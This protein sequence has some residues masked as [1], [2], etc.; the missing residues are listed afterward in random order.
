MKLP[1]PSMG[2][3]TDLD[4]LLEKMPVLHDPLAFGI[5]AE[6]ISN[7]QD[8]FPPPPVPPL[9]WASANSTWTS[10]RGPRNGGETNTTNVWSGNFISESAVPLRE[11][12]RF[13][14][15]RI[16][17]PGAFNLAQASC[18]EE[19]LRDLRKSR[20]EEDPDIF[21]HQF[22]QCTLFSYG[23]KRP[24]VVLTY[25]PEMLFFYAEKV[26]SFIP[27]RATDDGQD[28][29][30]TFHSKDEFLIHIPL[31]GHSTASKDEESLDD[32]CDKSSLAALRW[33]YK[34]KASVNF[35]R[36]VGVALEL[37]E[38]LPANPHIV[39]LWLSE[40]IKTVI[41]PTGI[42]LTDVDD[43]SP[44]L[45]AA[46]K[47]L[48][49]G[50]L[51]LK[52]VSVT[53]R[54][55]GILT[56]DR[57]DSMQAYIEYLRGVYHESL[58]GMPEIPDAALF[59]PDQPLHTDLTEADYESFELDER[60]YADYEEAIRKYIVDRQGSSDV[61][62]VFV[63][64]VVGCGRGP[65]VTAAINATMSS[66]ARIRIYALEKNPLTAGIL[67]GKCDAEW[68]GCDVRVV[69]EDMRT[70]QPPEKID[71]LLSEMLGG[72]GDNE[73]SPE[74]LAG[75]ERFLSAKG[76]S[77]PETYT[78]YIY[79]ISSTKLY[80]LFPDGRLEFREHVY[81]FDVDCLKALDEP[82]PVF[83]FVHPS[84]GN[85]EKEYYAILKFRANAPG[86][87]HGFAGCFTAKLYGDIEHSLLPGSDQ[88]PGP[89]QPGLD[90]RTPGLTTWKPVF[91]P[92]ATPYHLAQGQLICL[93]FWRRSDDHSVWYEWSLAEPSRSQVH[94]VDETERR[95]QRKEIRNTAETYS[96]VIHG[97]MK[98][99][100]ELN[101]KAE[102]YM[103]VLSRFIAQRNLAKVWEKLT[104]VEELA[105]E[106]A[107]P[108]EDLVNY[109]SKESLALLAA[110][111]GE[112]GV[113]KALQIKGAPRLYFE[114]GNLDGKKP[115]HE[116]VENGHRECVVYLAE[117]IGVSV[118]SLKRA[119]WTPL[120]L[121]CVKGNLDMIRYLVAHGADVHFENKDGWNA[122][123]L[124]CREG[125][126]EACKLLQE[127]DPTGTSESCSKNG[128]SPL[129]TAALHGRRS[130]VQFLLRECGYKPTTQ[131]ATGQTPIMNAK[132]AGHLELAQLM[133]SERL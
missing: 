72:F 50:F 77:I 125:N 6:G 20:M 7:L 24:P 108:W 25:A 74:C 55:S 65:L 19:N 70:W 131:D 8:I 48:L 101:C 129:H 99:S 39:H 124:A 100:A 95:E 79:P 88:P 62:D 16:L 116:A 103:R 12:C 44:Y 75:P 92:L 87:L 115:L 51:R 81:G 133:E 52:N 30:A 35:S 118:N 10:L 26:L 9:V 27:P 3:K 29:L 96:S 83:T 80:E 119:D 28:L 23:S 84:K 123:H 91:F 38:D 130:V 40:P 57:L 54:P 106:D 117:T 111:Y 132:T 76:V 110:R 42:F 98:M 102:T 22:R 86:M 78:S 2:T 69:M 1:G 90:Q 71:L 14:A 13:L 63:A 41:L 112:V 21:S 93:H 15:L 73:L 89:D 97:P 61:P 49:Q 17:V 53:L 109:P 68:K 31:A 5:Y 120:M 113:L 107:I 105:G 104:E 47:L 66:N 4:R 46:H 82:Q 18:L 64:A 37:S 121:A 45:S 67:A 122:F 58:T 36:K 33:W 127:L 59:P 11:I 85:N 128:R 126:L 32:S 60:K 114:I 94:N 43:N 56:H 34:L